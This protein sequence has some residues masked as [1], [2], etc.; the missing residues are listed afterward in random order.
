MLPR[1]PKKA[2]KLSDAIRRLADAGV[3]SP[4]HDARELFEHFGGYSRASLTGHDPESDEPALLDAVARRC[5]RYPLQYLIGEC[6]FYRE[7]YRVTPDVLIP[8]ADTE[9]LVDVAVR[10]CRGGER[11]LDLCTGSG[12]IPISVL[13]NTKNTAA[14]A[15][16]ISDG[17]LAVAR[18]NAARYALEGRIDFLKMDLL[19]DFPD[20]KWDIITANPPYIP[21]EVYETLAPEIASEPRIAFVAEEN[22]L[23]FYRRILEH[24]RAHLKEGGLFLF[25][26]GYDQREGITRLA[27]RYGLSVEILRDLGG[28]DRVAVIS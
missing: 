6:G 14:L 26:I 7:L 27:D 23:L 5:E 20:G 9:L 19:C 2:M 24:G 28:N 4:A 12:C 16:D 17:A 15:V 8:R 22:G 13:N 10:K 1:P 25:E 11:I 18:E 3:D 21:E